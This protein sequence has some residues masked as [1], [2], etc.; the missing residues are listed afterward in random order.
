MH[1][2]QQDYERFAPMIAESYGVPL[3]CLS[4]KKEK[5][6]QAVFARR[7]LSICLREMNY[8]YP[9]IADVMG[10]KSHTTIM[11]LCTGAYDRPSTSNR[12]KTA[13]SDLAKAEVEARTLLGDRKPTR[14]RPTGGWERPTIDNGRHEFEKAAWTYWRKMP[15]EREAF[16]LEYCQEAFPNSWWAQAS[17]PPRA[18]HAA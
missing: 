12:K 8:S 10:I 4:G 16:W 2:A 6:R 5:T 1:A 17:M 3:D 13:I 7:V 15:Y 9:E 14:V 18:V 11:R